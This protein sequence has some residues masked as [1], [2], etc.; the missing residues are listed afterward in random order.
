MATVTKS[1]SGGVINHIAHHS[2]PQDHTGHQQLVKSWT[3]MKM[4]ADL[5]QKPVASVFLRFLFQKLSL[6]ALLLVM[7]REGRDH[8]LVPGNVKAYS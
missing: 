6:H 7:S 4:D 3:K 8:F 1:G 2:H 5:F